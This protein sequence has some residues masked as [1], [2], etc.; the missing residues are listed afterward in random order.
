MTSEQLEKI[1]TTECTQH[2]FGC[3]CR[4]HQLD[5]YRQAMSNLRSFVDSLVLGEPVS[6]M[7]IEYLRAVSMA[8]LG[9][10]K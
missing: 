9:E 1:M 4:E 8:S 5:H 6:I 2:S 10:R 7:H 3:P